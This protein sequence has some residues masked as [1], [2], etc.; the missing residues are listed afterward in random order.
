MN[1]FHPDQTDQIG[2]APFA[3]NNQPYQANSQGLL[4]TTDHMPLNNGYDHP[5]LPSASGANSSTPQIVFGPAGNAAIARAIDRDQSDLAAQAQTRLNRPTG[6]VRSLKTEDQ[7]RDRV[8]GLYKYSRELRTD[9]PQLPVEPSPIDLVEDLITSAQPGLNGSAPRRSIASWRLY[10][11]ALLWH[12]A[13]SRHLHP[14]FESAYQDLAAIQTPSSEIRKSPV[15]LK[16][17]FLAGDFALLVNQLGSMNQRGAVWGSRTSYWLQAG[18]VAGARG[19]EWRDTRW[20]DRDKCLL[21]IPNSKRKV[22]APAFKKMREADHLNVKSVFDLQ[23]P[24]S[25]NAAQSLGWTEIEN[26][27]SASMSGFE[28]GDH[29]NGDDNEDAPLESHRVVQINRNDAIYVDMHLI[30][31]YTHRKQQAAEGIGAELAFT[32]YTGMARTTLRNACAILFKGKRHYT[33][34]HTRS[35]FA[36]NMKVDNSIGAVAAMMGHTSTRTTMGSYG[37]RLSGLRSKGGIHLMPDG[38]RQ[39]IADADTDTE[40]SSIDTAWFTDVG[41]GA[42]GDQSA[43]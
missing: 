21:L 24:I 15:R 9:D 6:M 8:R 33:L 36:A 41:A 23:P 28:E 20:L 38:L 3:T 39:I 31:I 12:L 22:S 11:S 18:V 32:R 1:T 17:T 34:R 35:Q 14:L 7:Y 2:Q 40:S 4:D 27:G 5:A 19:I 26:Q 29:G 16:K 42:G 13:M 25:I 43:G 10:R 37:S 30:S